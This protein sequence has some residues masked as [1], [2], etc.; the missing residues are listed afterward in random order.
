MLNILNKNLLQYFDNFQEHPEN[1]EKV[2]SSKIN[3]KQRYMK[4]LA[5]FKNKCHHFNVY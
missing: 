2:I 1:A 4:H 3:S 5:L